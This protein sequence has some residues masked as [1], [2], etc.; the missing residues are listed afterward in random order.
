MLLSDGVLCALRRCPRAEHRRARMSHDSVARALGV[1]AQAIKL[2]EDVVKQAPRVS[3]PYHTLGLIH[4]EMQDQKRALECYLIAAFLTAKDVDVWKRVARMSQEQGDLRQASYCINRALR[5]TPND[6]GALNTRAE[7]LLLRGQRTQAR[8]PSPPLL[9]IVP[10]SDSFPGS[11]CS[12]ERASP[13]VSGAR[14]SSG[15]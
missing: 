15:C 8:P 11:Q 14:V 1:A 2:L 13:P 10:L 7:L 12:L 9:R 6:C 5:L 3:D 4:E